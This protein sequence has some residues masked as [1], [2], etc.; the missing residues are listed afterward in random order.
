IGRDEVLG[1]CVL[2]HQ[3][4]DIMEEAHGGI[5]G[6]HYAGDAPSRKILLAGLWWETLYKNCKEYCK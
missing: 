3:H 5:T 1:R 4:K 2:E 6:G